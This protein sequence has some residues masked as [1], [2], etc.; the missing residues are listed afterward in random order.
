MISQVDAVVK[1]IAEVLG[2]DFV[3][4]Q[5]VVSEVLTSDQKRAIREAVTDQIVNGE[6]RFNKSVDDRAKV[7]HYVN[8]MINNHLVKSRKLNGGKVHTPKKTGSVRDPQLKELNKLLSTL[9]P[10]TVEYNKVLGSIDERKAELSSASSAIDTS[11]VPNE[12]AG[13]VNP[14]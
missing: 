5:T 12:V 6:V 8:G 13:I 14:T 11:I 2:D 10:N 7:S 9:N 4:G 3:V 1:A